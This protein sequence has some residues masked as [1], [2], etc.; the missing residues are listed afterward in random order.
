MWMRDGDRDRAG[1]ASK[2]KASGWLRRPNLPR[3]SSEG[4]D[5]EG[6]RMPDRW[7]GDGGRRGRCGHAL[8][9][10]EQVAAV[11]RDRLQRR[12]AAAVHGRP[13]DVARHDLRPGNGA[14]HAGRH[15]PRREAACVATA[16]VRATATRDAA[17]AVA[18]KRPG[19]AR[20]ALPRRLVVGGVA[21]RA[22]ARRK[23]RPLARIL[24]CPIGWQARGRVAPRD[25]DARVSRAARDLR[26]ANLTAADDRR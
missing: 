13:V 20:A 23:A 12:H 5:D 21:R 18:V 11:R 17:A 26:G 1:R 3:A 8:H 15:R 16:A 22:G 24:P 7:N 4:F 9:V 2:C 6:N 19:T 14:R 10:R 25:R